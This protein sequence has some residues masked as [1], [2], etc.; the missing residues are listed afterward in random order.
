M[1]TPITWANP[2]NLTIINEKKHAQRVENLEE[3]KKL[4]QKKSTK[5]K[6]MDMLNKSI[7]AKWKPSFGM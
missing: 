6:L 2:D 1:Y 7:A 5:T 3:K 4:Y